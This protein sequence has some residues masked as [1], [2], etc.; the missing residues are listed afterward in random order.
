MMILSILGGAAL[1]ARYKVFCLAPI[2]VIAI[3]VIA[4]LD[5]LNAVPLSSTVLTAIALA[6]GL[7][8]GY[9]GGAAARLA[10]AGPH[11]SIIESRRHG[12]QPAKSF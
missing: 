4:T 12:D 5:R 10:C 3:T 1:G 11:G 7:Q 9:F 8:V 6:V 2:M